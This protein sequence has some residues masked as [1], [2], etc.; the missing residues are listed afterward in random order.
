MES[1]KIMVVDLWLVKVGWQPLLKRF[2]P[3]LKRDS[4]R[5][6]PLELSLLQPLGVL[7]ALLSMKQIN[8][9]II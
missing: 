8:G 1:V 6:L 2:T 3:I 9:S 7:W 5:I 4:L